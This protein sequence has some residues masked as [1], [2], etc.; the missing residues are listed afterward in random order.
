MQA[1]PIVWGAVDSGNTT[2]DYDEESKSEALRLQ[3]LRASVMAGL[4][5]QSD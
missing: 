3:R 5:H 4:H 2:T 1:Q